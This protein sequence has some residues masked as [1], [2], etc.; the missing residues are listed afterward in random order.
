MSLRRPAVFEGLDD[1]FTETFGEDEVILT[2]DGVVQDPITGIVRWPQEEG[3][4]DVQR[5]VVTDQPFAR[6]RQQDC[7]GLSD[8]DLLAF[9]G[10]TFKV[11]DVADDG[12]GMT[13][14]MLSVHAE[15]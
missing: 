15:A 2:I 9:D 12:R 11:H 10:T 1:A 8:G 5:E 3:F 13:G 6:L 14:M 7:V 4:A